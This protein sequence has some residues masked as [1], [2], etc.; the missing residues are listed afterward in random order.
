MKGQCID[1]RFFQPSDD[2][3]RFPVLAKCI[4]PDPRVGIPLRN[5]YCD[6][7]RRDAWPVS[8]FFGSCGRGGRFFEPKAEDRS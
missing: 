1:C 6:S 8:V 4:R 7:D 3:E 2:P 5:C